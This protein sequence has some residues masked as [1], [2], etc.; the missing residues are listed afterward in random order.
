L[1]EGDAESFRHLCLALT[2]LQA[3]GTQPRA[4]VLIDKAGLSSHAKYFPAMQALPLSHT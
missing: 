3:S 2:S 1:L 4:D